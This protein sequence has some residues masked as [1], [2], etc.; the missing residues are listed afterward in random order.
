MDVVELS[1]KTRGH[2]LG[3]F[4]IDLTVVS[5]DGKVWSI[6]EAGQ[7]IITNRVKFLYESEVVTDLAVLPEI[8]NALRHGN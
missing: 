8:P 5:R 3:G 4:R 6:E 2:N 7:L 1:H